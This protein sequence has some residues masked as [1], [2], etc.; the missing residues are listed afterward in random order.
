MLGRRAALSEI[1]R[2]AALG[3]GSKDGDKVQRGA[4]GQ[5][6][7][8]CTENFALHAEELLLCV[9]VVHQVAE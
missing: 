5:V 3:N 9:G 6:E 7:L 1:Y 2:S 8:E 4:V